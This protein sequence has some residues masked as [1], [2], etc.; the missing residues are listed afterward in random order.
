M[1]FNRA[2]YQNQKHKNAT[3]AVYFSESK[4]FYL[5]MMVDRVSSTRIV[6]S[7]IPFLSLLRSSRSLYVTKLLICVALVS[8]L[9]VATGPPLVPTP[10]RAPPPIGA[11]PGYTGAGHTGARGPP[12]GS[13]AYMAMSATSVT[14]SKA[15]PWHNRYPRVSDAGWYARQRDNQRRGVPGC[16]ICQSLDHYYDHYINTVPDWA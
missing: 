12:V 3:Q 6:I 14:F 9:F 15:V 8:C 10:P 16:V 1:H 13:A 2:L 7:S 5:R 4:K 11:G